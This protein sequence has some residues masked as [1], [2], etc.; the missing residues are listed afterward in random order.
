MEICPRLWH[1]HCMHVWRFHRFAESRWLTIGTSC[2]TMLAA[3]MIGISDLVKHIKKNCTSLF[4]LRGFDRLDAG[5][6]EFMA[7]CA[8]ASRVPEAIQADLMRDNRVAKTADALWETG[9]KELKWAIDLPDSTYTLLADLCNSSGSALKDRCIDAA[10][11]SFHFLYRRVL[12]VA[13]ELPW[14]LC[15]GDIGQNL[16]DLAAQECPDEPVSKN[17]WLLLHRRFNKAQLIATVEMIGE[18]GWTSLPAEQQ[19]ASL[20]M[21]HK[22]HPEYDMTTLISRSLLLQASKLLPAA[23]KEEK[24]A[25]QL[26][27]KLDFI[28]R[29]HPDKVRG[30]QMLLGSMVRICSDKK[31]AWG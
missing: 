26:S 27:A 11:T 4:F 24:L 17:L 3:F 12:E 28:L 9:A 21:L 13:G 23:S 15:R 8:V 1:R 19:H 22:W 5:R 14:C 16:D 18:V 30:R 31:D 7:M 20:A 10:H 29:S 6:L 25:A 2:R